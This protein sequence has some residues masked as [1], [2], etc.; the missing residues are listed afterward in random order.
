MKRIVALLLAVIL[1]FSCC[2]LTAFAQN[3]KISLGLQ[4]KLKNCDPDDMVPV[5]ITYAIKTQKMSDMPSWPGE[6]ASAEYGE[7]CNSVQEE[8]QAQIFEGLDVN[9]RLEIMSWSVIA[10]VKA[11]DIETIAANDAV[12]EIEYFENGTYEPNDEPPT[13]ATESSQTTFERFNEE[14]ITNVY[15]DDDDDDISWSDIFYLYDELYEHHDSDGNT[16]W[17]L[18]HVEPYVGKTAVYR[19]VIGNRALRK[20]YE[21]YPFMSGYGIYDVKKD[22]FVSV[23][24]GM[25]NDY[26]GLANAYDEFGEGRLLGDIDNDDSI[27]VV[28][29]TVMQRC[30]TKIRDYPVND[31]IETALRNYTGTC[32]FSDFNRDG[33]RD[34]L[35]ATCIQRY[36]VGMDYPIG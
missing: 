24:G 18:L 30:D 1:V 20:S 9:I 21:S 22:T 29:A 19:D 10:D 2:I 5:S 23:Y 16:V 7:Y 6:A 12:R 8:M 15:G 35:D 17:V 4:E 11:R 31:E 36:L 34:I 32:Y 13:Y 27:T 28:D 14:F 33:E 3:S 26:D 25:V